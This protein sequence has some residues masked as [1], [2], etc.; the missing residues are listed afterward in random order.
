MSLL[1][2][3][4]EVLAVALALAGAIAFG[5]LIWRRALLDVQSKAMQVQSDAIA[6]YEGRIKQLEEAR[7]QDATIMENLRRE[8]AE[9]R[10]EIKGQR[11]LAQA[12]IETIA[13]SRVCLMAPDCPNRVV[14]S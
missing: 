5:W 1:K 10:G 14:P 11:D 4:G 9:L 8:L 12:I 6:A 7:E 2:T 13:D 3:A